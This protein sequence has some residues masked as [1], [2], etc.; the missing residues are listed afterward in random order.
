[1]LT[2]DGYFI[3]RFQA[4]AACFASPI[5]LLFLWLTRCR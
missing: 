4:T 1:M 5:W 2:V 3:P